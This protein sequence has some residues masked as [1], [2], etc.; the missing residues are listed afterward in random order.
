MYSNFKEVKELKLNEK[1]T[2]DL[3]ILMFHIFNVLNM[4]DN[5]LSESDR[6]EAV[7]DFMKLEGVDSTEVLKHFLNIGLDIE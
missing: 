2:H 4:I 3:K 1:Q 7:Q 6:L 5:C